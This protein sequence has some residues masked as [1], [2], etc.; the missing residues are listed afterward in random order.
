[1]HNN[2]TTCCFLHVPLCFSTCLTCETK[3]SSVPKVQRESPV[4]LRGT[5]LSSVPTQSPSSAGFQIMRVCLR[6]T[7]W[8][9]LIVTVTQG[10]N[11]WLVCSNRTQFL[12]VTCHRI[13]F[14]TAYM[15]VLEESIKKL[16]CSMQN[17]QHPEVSRGEKQTRW[18]PR[19]SEA[20][21]PV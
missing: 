13:Q 12:Q 5:S 14:G 21:A 3:L 4:F 17:L 19:G 20:A 1:M 16:T 7:M 2:S 15:C 8:H 11:C 10:K 6:W 18:T 9:L